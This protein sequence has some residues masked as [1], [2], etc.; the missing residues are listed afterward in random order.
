MLNYC[1]L[2]DHFYLNKALVMY[3]SLRRVCPSFH[4]Y[5]FA[6]DGRAL[7]ILQKMRL[8]HVTVISQ[9][10]F[11]SEDLLRVKPGRTRAEYCWTCT[12]FTI[13]YCIKN[14]NLSECTYIDADLFFIS[15][16]SVL[17]QEMGD[18]SV[19]ITEH[20]YTPAYDA[21]RTHGIYCV[22]YITFKN[23]AQGIKVLHWWRDRCL[24][25]CY[26]RFEDGKFGDQ[27]YLDDWTTRFEGVHV[28]QHIGGGLAPWNIQQYR[29]MNET[30]GEWLLERKDGTG[31]TKAVFYHFHYV[32]FLPHGKIDISPYDLEGEGALKLY[33]Y[34]IRETLKINQS[35]EPYSMKADDFVTKDKPDLITRLRLLKKRLVTGIHNVY[36]IETLTARWQG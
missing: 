34:Y 27:K 24:E 14:Y 13:D 9:A 3:E 15:D 25:W 16:P 36:K 32:K 19:L 5:I 12:P 26:N 21:S 18:R 7:E 6:F 35:L 17:H 30:N 28:L 10:E 31:R 33:A 11:E 22:Q 20:R 4:L 29:L 2:F 8:E 23:N 1:T